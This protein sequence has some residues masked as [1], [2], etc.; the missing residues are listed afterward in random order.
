MY[1]IF[2]AAKKNGVQ[3][4]IP[5]LTIKRDGYVGGMIGQ[6]NIEQV[7]ETEGKK[8]PDKLMMLLTL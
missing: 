5:S 2:Y 3:F 8:F 6:L 1:A 4:D 7:V